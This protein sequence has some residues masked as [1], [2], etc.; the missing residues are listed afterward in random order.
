MKTGNIKS[1]LSTLLG[2]I[3]LQL[4]A[5]ALYAAAASCPEW[6]T[7]RD[8]YGIYTCPQYTPQQSLWSLMECSYQ[9][10]NNFTIPTPEQKDLTRR[11]VN[12]MVQ[13]KPAQM[14]AIG[15]RLNL[16]FCRTRKRNSNGVITDS[17]LVGIVKP[18]YD[19]NG[20]FFLFR[21]TSDAARILMEVPHDDF[22][23]AAIM[24]VFDRSNAYAL[25][26][27]GQRRIAVAAPKCSSRP[28]SDAAH[29]TFHGF[30]D[31]HL[32]FVKAQPAMIVLHLHGM[33]KRGMIVTNG[34]EAK[35]AQGSL[36]QAATKIIWEMYPNRDDL[37]SCA[38][39]TRL[40]FRANCGINQAWVQIKQLTCS[41]G[42]QC[43][44]G[45]KNT[46]RALGFELN[47]R[48]VNTEFL[49]PLMQKLNEE[50]LELNPTPKNCS[51]RLT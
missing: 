17:I 1:K 37:Y 12:A 27:N 44:P 49:L 45:N 8:R 10:T 46:D 30:Y 42:P 6:T 16:Q 48:Y 41:P 38:A 50:Y 14:V 13:R 32:A 40:T 39:G 2:I 33:S 43:K 47:R 35:P 21:E 19:Y 5:K 4:F 11:L 25:I 26:K 18:G 15:A 28:A 22:S 36:M 51:L 29:S 24:R 7:Q 23:N 34:L 3:W 20:A 31:A 9:Q